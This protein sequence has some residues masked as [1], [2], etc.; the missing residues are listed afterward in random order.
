MASPE[1]TRIIQGVPGAGKSSTLSERTAQNPYADFPKTL[2]VSSV[3]ICDEFPRRS[4]AIGALG[5]SSKSKLETMAETAIRVLGSLAVLD[6]PGSK[7][8]PLNQSVLFNSNDWF[9][10]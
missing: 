2:Q 4:E 9:F 8:L 10:A 7:I 5:V 3:E 1:N 6:V